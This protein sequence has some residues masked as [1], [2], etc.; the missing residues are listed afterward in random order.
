MP[1]RPQTRTTRDPD[2]HER[3]GHDPDVDDH[4]RRAI[5]GGTAGADGERRGDGHERD[6]VVVP[7][8][9]ELTSVAVTT[10][11]T[12]RRVA[13]AQGGDHGH[14]DDRGDDGDLDP[15]QGG[16]VEPGRLPDERD[17][18][19]VARVDEPGPGAGPHDR[20]VVEPDGDPADEHAHRDDPEPGHDSRAEHPGVRDR[21][22]RAR[23]AAQPT[24]CSGAGWSL[25]IEMIATAIRPATCIRRVEP[26]SAASRSAP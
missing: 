8:D 17:G 22:V 10:I 13:D 5:H 2:P 21:R 6:R 4:D 24:A 14:D 12:L 11:P 25:A 16:A 19:D 26:G 7:G 23:R 1:A 18:P 15:A 9:R 20:D 3:Q